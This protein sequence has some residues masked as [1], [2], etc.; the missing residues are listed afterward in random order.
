MKRLFPLMLFTVVA[1]FFGGSLYQQI[2][3]QRWRKLAEEAQSQAA[4]AIEHFRQCVNE[5]SRNA[6]ELTDQQNDLKANLEALEAVFSAF[7][8]ERK[9]APPS[10]R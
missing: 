4:T 10:S 6:A 3:T 9:A 7:E 8:K 2:E 1:G 5:G